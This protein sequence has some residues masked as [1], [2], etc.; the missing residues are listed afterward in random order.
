[1]LAQQ[2][3]GGGTSESCL[4]DEAHESVGWSELSTVLAINTFQS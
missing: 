1:M 2:L 3:E 4:R